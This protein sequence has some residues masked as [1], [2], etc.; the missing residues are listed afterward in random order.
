MVDLKYH[1]ILMFQCAWNKPVYTELDEIGLY[2]GRDMILV[3]L[4]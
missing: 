2:M 3:L 4:A 1:A